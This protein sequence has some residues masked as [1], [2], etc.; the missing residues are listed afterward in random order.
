VEVNARNA[1][2]SGF[3]QTQL[4]ESLQIN[5]YRKRYDRTKNKH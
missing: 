2:E 3:V 5:L 1:N 4:C